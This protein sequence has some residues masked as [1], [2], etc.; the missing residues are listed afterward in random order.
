M[1]VKIYCSV[2]KQDQ[3]YVEAIDLGFSICFQY[4][5]ACKFSGSPSYCLK[6]MGLSSS[7]RKQI[8]K[9]SSRKISPYLEWYLANSRNLIFWQPVSV[10]KPLDVIHVQQ[11]IVRVAC[12]LIF[13]SPRKTSLF[14]LFCDRKERRSFL[15]GF[16]PLPSQHSY[17]PQTSCNRSLLLHTTAVPRNIPV[18][19]TT[20][21][22]CKPPHYAMSSP[23]RS[24]LDCCDTCD[25][26]NS[27]S[28]IAG[29]P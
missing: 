19:A 27:S 20:I 8:T 15:N 17:M 14:D 28:T 22:S 12:G 4:L 24:R 7:I 2:P 21:L 26:A 18:R 9:C 25:I 1:T 3:I 11:K 23:G 6:Y 29:N 13:T 5:C 16:K 10:K